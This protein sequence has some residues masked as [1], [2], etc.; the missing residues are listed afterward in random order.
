M[1]FT[2]YCP[3]PPSMFDGPLLLLIVGCFVAPPLVWWLRRSA[4]DAHDVLT[5][6]SSPR[7]GRLQGFRDLL[8]WTCV[9]V[10]F[11]G[12]V[13][14]TIDFVIKLDLELFDTVSSVLDG[15]RDTGH[16]ESNAPWW[17]FT[18][19]T[20]LGA[21]LRVGWLRNASSGRDVLHIAHPTA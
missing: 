12:P 16:V 2:M 15:G 18:A 9:A 17:T 21:I 14:L 19:M 8:M 20:V 4:R 3:P 10:A 13:L 6:G 11:I 7:Q 1:Q 5:S